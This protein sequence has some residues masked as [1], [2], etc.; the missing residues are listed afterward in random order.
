MNNAIEL[1]SPTIL[2]Q[3]I[4]ILCFLPIHCFVGHFVFSLFVY[5]LCLH[6]D[7]F[8]IPKI[9]ISKHSIFPRKKWRHSIAKRGVGVSTQ[10]ERSLLMIFYKD[11]WSG[12]GRSREDEGPIFI[13]YNDLDDV[14]I[15]KMRQN[16]VDFFHNLKKKFFEISIW[17]WLCTGS[18]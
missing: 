10:S 5:Y 4:S 15:N 9:R 14:F 11:W 6:I 2:V 13:V 3:V 18:P 1:I 12:K 16:V 8:K 17:I 7:K